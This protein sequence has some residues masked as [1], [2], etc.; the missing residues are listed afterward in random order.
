MGCSSMRSLLSGV[1]F[2][3]WG[4]GGG[5][6]SSPAPT[7]TS[8]GGGAPNASIGPYPDDNARRMPVSNSLTALEAGRRK[9]AQVIK[10][11]GRASTKLAGAGTS[12]YVNANIGGTQ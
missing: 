2:G 10:S 11:S 12:P 5:G 4:G 3:P 1:C 6:S 7:P 8:S 9:R